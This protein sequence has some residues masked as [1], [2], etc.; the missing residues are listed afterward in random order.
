M[1]PDEV[2]AKQVFEIK[3]SA[4]ETPATDLGIQE[5]RRGL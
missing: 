3:V 5:L 2:L 4:V 1:T